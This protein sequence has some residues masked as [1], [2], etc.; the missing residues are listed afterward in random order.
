MRAEKNSC[1]CADI[2]Q[3]AL[4]AAYFIAD[5]ILPIRK[6]RFDYLCLI[7]ARYSERIFRRI[8]AKNAAHLSSYLIRQNLAA[9]GLFTDKRFP[10]TLYD[11]RHAVFIRGC[12]RATVKWRYH[13]PMEYPST[14][15]DWADDI[16]RFLGC[17]SKNAKGAFISGTCYRPYWMRTA[18]F[19]IHT[20][21][22]D[23]DAA[24]H[25]WLSE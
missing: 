14:M 4:A 13:G 18:S 21:A 22:Q 7:S 20:C 5:A 2:S 23:G 11:T 6:L 17:A 3:H 25:K 8:D 19:H 15:G 12:E 9:S 16:A 24:W 10:F 1:Y